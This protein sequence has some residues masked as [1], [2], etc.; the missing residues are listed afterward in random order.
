MYAAIKMEDS[1]PEGVNIFK[2]IQDQTERN[3]GK[4]LLMIK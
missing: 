4:I 2:E 3:S 1:L